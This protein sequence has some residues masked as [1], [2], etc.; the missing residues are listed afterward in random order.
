MWDR[1]GSAGCSAISPTMLWLGRTPMRSENRMSVRR[2]LIP[3][4]LALLAAGCSDERHPT[5]T[6]QTTAPVPHFLRW[7]DAVTP[8]FSAV[9]A[10]STTESDDRLEA[11]LTGGGNAQLDTAP[12]LA[13]RGDTPSVPVQCLRVACGTSL[14]SPVRPPN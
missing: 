12:F 11:S 2:V 6:P 7:A 1:C 13:G 8:Q 3:L 10:V 14:L 5:G 4:A 9:G